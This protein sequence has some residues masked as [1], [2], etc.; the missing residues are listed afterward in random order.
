MTRYDLGA[1]LYTAVPR[2]PVE[3]RNAIASAERRG[4]SRDRG[5]PKGVLYPVSGKN[6]FAISYVPG[7]FWGPDPGARLNF[8]TS[9]PHSHRRLVT[10]EAAGDEVRSRIDTIIRRTSEQVD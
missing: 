10:F 6:S 1:A 9:P 3:D 2:C 7:P 8:R 4:L 5:A